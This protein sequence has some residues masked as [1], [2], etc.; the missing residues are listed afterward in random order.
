MMIPAT[1][2]DVTPAWLGEV[3]NLEVA[4]ISVEQIGQGVGLMG[5]IYCVALET[6]ALETGV[7]SLKSVVVKLPSSFEGNRTQGVALGMF[8]AEVKFYSELAQQATVGMPRVYH[9]EIIEG[10]ADFVIVMED[11][12]D[13]IS[14]AQLE[15][16]SFDQALAAVKVLA[17]IHAVW[18][19]KV[20]VDSLEWIP[21]MIGPR[22]EYVDQLLAEI[23]PIFADGFGQHLPA[24]G[25]E[26]YEQ[27]AGNYLKINTAISG[28]SP[29]T[30][31]HQDYRVENLLFGE[32][33]SGKAIVLDWQGIG[34]GPGAYDLAYLLGGSMTVPARRQHEVE[35]VRAYHDELLANEVDD[36]SFDQA[37]DDYG[38]A[39]L[40]GGLAVAMV[41]AGTLD[42]SN[43]RGKQLVASMAERHVTAALDHDGLARLTAI[44]GQ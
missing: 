38:H 40:M 9:A 15:G 22:I 5:D 41:T 20:Q 7:D 36:Y 11:L 44:I 43:D 42:L 25:L 26:L 10:T 24:G 18:W 30:L 19:D 33:G 8:D 21:S 29:W 14:V 2:N 32:P 35:L 6:G 13:L 37:F 28:R 23:Y 17:A 39:H 16:M 12:S 4:G 1:I 27:F 3:L 34:R 31:A